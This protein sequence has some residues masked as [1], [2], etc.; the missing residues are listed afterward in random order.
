[1]Y[2]AVMDEQRI[3]FIGTGTIGKPI[4]KCLLS[5]YSSMIVF[6]SNPSACEELVALGA[7]RAHKLA[8]VASDCEIV[9][10]SLPGPTQIAAVMQGEDGLLAHAKSLSTI[11]DLST[12]ALKLNRKIANQAAEKDISYL[13]APVSGGARAALKGALS[14]MVG[15]DEAA[16][17]KVRP[18]IECFAEHISY[19][20][21]SGAGTLTKLVNNQ[22]FL[23]ASVLVQEGFLMGAK[24]GMDPNAL[25]EVLK[26]SSAAP[27]VKRAPLVLSRDFDMGVF[28]LGIAAK[29][30]AVA[31]E[32]AR[33]L[34]VSM[35]MTEAANA[36]YQQALA[37]GLDEKDF[38]ATVKVLEQM[39]NVE[40]PPLITD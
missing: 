37:S 20:G 30:V 11:V 16:F 35:P 14:V 15:G 10:A 24:A 26:A 23:C 32:S 22:I 7:K 21:G 18:V 17:K 29:D 39:A 5:E 40:L 4:A 36:I 8:E 1:M 25:L 9:F 3:G 27:M 12:N 38:F 13:D 6:D 28:S 33:D 2:G 31:L 34:G 19:M